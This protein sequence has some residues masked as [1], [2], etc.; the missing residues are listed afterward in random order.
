MPPPT[1]AAS[2]TPRVRPPYVR[3]AAP[4]L[5][6]VVACLRAERGE[7][8]GRCRPGAIVCRRSIVMCVTELFN[9]GLRARGLSF[10][11]RSA[12]RRSAPHS[13]PGVCRTAA[14]IS[15]NVMGRAA[16]CH[17]SYGWLSHHLH[18]RCRPALGAQRPTARRRVA[19]LALQRLRFRDQ[20]GLA[21]TSG[22]I[23]IGS[24]VSYRDQKKQIKK[25]KKKKNILS[26]L[27]ASRL[28][29]SV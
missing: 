12:R 9:S 8:A 22:H 4:S 1:R 26:L 27:H 19:P 20:H 17:E 5:C 18:R 2:A 21:H 23:D 14:T 6:R 16:G 28:H 25:K 3:R 10:A 11:S 7:V 15:C 29:Y 24:H 13:G